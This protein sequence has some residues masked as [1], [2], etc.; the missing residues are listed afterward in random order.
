MRLAFRS[1]KGTELLI[2]VGVDTV[3]LKGKPFQLNVEQGQTFKKGDLLMEFDMEAIKAAGKSIETV[4]A[5]TNTN[6]KEPALV[7]VGSLQQL[8]PVLVLN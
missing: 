6:E 4:V 5:I 8:E 2:H 3:E 1:T 7:N